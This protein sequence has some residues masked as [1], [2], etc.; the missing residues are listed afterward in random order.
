MPKRQKHQE[1]DLQ[2][3][4]VKWFAYEYPHLR[5][6]LYHPK[7]EG[8]A[9]GRLQGAIAKAEGVVPGVADLI[10]QLPAGNHACLAIEMKTKTGRQSKEQKLWQFYLTA[11]QGCYVIVRS[12]EQFVDVVTSYIAS[13]DKKVLAALHSV[14]KVQLRV[15]EDTARERFKKIINTSK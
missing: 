6:L 12:H 13:A 7:N 14:H 8:H 1:S 5:M 3:R 10:L 9:R 11:A 2:I 4:C 15:E